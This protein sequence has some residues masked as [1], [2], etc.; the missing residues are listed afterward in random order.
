M[1]K[2]LFLT[3]LFGCS[4]AGATTTIYGGTNLC[5][6]EDSVLTTDVSA[7]IATAITT[8]G[9]TTYSVY[10]GQEGQTYT[11][12]SLTTT[13][14]IYLNTF[15]TNGFNRSEITAVSLDL[16]NGSLTTAGQLTFDTSSA[17]TV[18]ITLGVNKS[19]NAGS[20]EIPGGSNVTINMAEGAAVNSNSTINLSSL[21][22]ALTLNTAVAEQDILA[23]VTAGTLYDRTL[24]SCATN[25]MWYANGTDS[26]HHNEL[27]SLHDAALD[28][29]GYTNLGILYTTDNGQTFTDKEGN[30]VT[31]EGRQY[32]L[33][34]YGDSNCTYTGASAP[35]S[36]HLIA[37]PEP[38][39]ATLS[40]LALAG[41]AAR[42]RR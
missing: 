14:D 36:M 19:I 2:A 9:D 30:L 37:T 10:F 25:T 6:G 4:L 40:L 3:V 1:K 26:S 31:L 38:A 11:E 24:I 20:I 27:V 41:L 29:A 17:K 39:T 28:A 34:F 35:S 22:T 16:T 21:N 13:Q 15:G 18:T 23:A 7:D 12:L 42:R 5:I 33:A 8:P 32:A